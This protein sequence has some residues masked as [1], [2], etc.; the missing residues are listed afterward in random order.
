MDISS[1]CTRLSALTN[2]RCGLGAAAACRPWNLFLA[3]CHHG[4]LPS[5]LCG[6]RPIQFLIPPF[7][8]L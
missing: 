2:V 4:T 5:L 8:S 7:P 3:T 6:G 1:R